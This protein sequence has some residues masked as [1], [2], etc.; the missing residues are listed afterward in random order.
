MPLQPTPLHVVDA[1]QGYHVNCVAVHGGDL[2]LNR[3]GPCLRR[4]ASKRT[5][6]FKKNC[7]V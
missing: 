3:V 5:L 6:L 2:D 7:I 1:L 4:T